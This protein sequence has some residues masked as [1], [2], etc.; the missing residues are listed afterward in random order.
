ML[1]FHRA[2]NVLK[3]S[4]KHLVKHVNVLS[5]VLKLDQVKMSTEVLNEKLEELKLPSS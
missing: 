4:K 3:R 1:A 2:K 5:E